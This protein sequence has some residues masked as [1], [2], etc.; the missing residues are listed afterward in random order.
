MSH[1]VSDKVLE[2]F[3]K[4][5]LDGKSQRV[6]IPRSDVFYIKAHLEQVFNKKFPLDYVERCMF[7]EGF[8]KA[9][10]VFQPERERPWETQSHTPNS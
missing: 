3:Y 4:N 1:Y 2:E 10:D 8:L 9:S 5:L 7:L 6:H